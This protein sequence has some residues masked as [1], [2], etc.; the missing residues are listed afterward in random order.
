MIETPFSF[1]DE[2]GLVLFVEK[3]GEKYR[4]FDDGGIV[5]HFANR[6]VSLSS[7]RSLRFVT[8]AC[9]VNGAIF[10]DHGEIETW[11]Q[12]N[13]PAEGF[14]RIVGTIHD[15]FAWERDHADTST[16]ISVLIEDVALCL[17]AI[18]P[19]AEIKKHPQLSG[20]SKQTHVF[21]FSWDDTIVSAISPHHAAVG[22]LLRKLIDVKG[23]PHHQSLNT[24]VVIDDRVDEA[25]ATR[26]A[27]VVSGVSTV[28]GM[29]ALQEKASFG[30]QRH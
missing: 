16:D 20:L 11:S 22:G 19:T 8:N 29:K 4:F 17:R 28:I 2:D 21:D 1:A 30:S 14:A 6:G 18:K 3:I 13:D 25:A 27:A 10:N 9:T 24:L 23:S 5:M 15:L 26:E 7:G 12:A